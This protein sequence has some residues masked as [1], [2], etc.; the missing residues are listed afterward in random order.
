MKKDSK[1]RTA[2]ISW[3]EVEK[4]LKTDNLSKVIFDESENYIKLI[5]PIIKKRDE[6]GL[7]QRELAEICELPQ[8]TIA[9][10]ETMATTANIR[11]L[12]KITK[13]LGLKITIS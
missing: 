12:I 7:S 11:S 3:K 5:A 4:K 6:L 1:K 2:S 10:I 13:A 9:R 8:S